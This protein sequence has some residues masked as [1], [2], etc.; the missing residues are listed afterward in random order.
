LY[1]CELLYGKE[2]AQSLADGLVIEWDLKKV[3]H[4]IIKK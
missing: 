1:V 3:P 2:I 4:L